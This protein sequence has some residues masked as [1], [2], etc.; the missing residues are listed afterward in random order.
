MNSLNVLYAIPLAAIMAAPV[1][2]QA[3]YYPPN[4]YSHG[5]NAPVVVP[6]TIINTAPARTYM[7]HESKK[8]CNETEIDLFLFRIGKTSGDCTP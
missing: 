2:A 5:N 6:P 8:S 3:Q 4:Y 1:S 7:D